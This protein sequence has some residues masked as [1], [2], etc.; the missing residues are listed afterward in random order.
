M[1][2]SFEDIHRGKVTASI[3]GRVFKAKSHKA[4]E[5]LRK[6]IMSGHTMPYRI[7]ACLFGIKNEPKALYIYEHHYLRLLPGWNTYR[8]LPTKTY[9]ITDLIGATPDATFVST[10]SEK[11][12]KKLVEIKVEWYLIHT[13][14]KLRL[15]SDYFSKTRTQSYIGPNNWHSKEF[16]CWQTGKWELISQTIS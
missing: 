5:N 11:P 12:L 6:F 16:L 4:K 13:I 1:G 14:L 10:G 7:P 9:W 8:R 15:L 3:A 2:E